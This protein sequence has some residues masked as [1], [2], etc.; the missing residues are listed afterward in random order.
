[1]NRKIFLLTLCFLIALIPMLFGADKID[2][3]EKSVVPT[4]TSPRNLLV[5]KSPAYKPIN[6][7]GK[8]G[9]LYQQIP[10]PTVAWGLACQLDTVYPMVSDIVDDIDPTGAGWVIDS[11][12]SYWSNW[13]GFYTWTLVPFID[14]LV[15][16]DDGT[17][18][19]EDSAFIKVRVPQAYYTATSIGTGEQYVVD[20]EL[21]TPVT[22]PGGAKYW[23]EVRPCT[24]FSQNGQ[25]GWMSEPGI[26][27]GQDLYIRFPLLGI[28]PWSD[29]TT[30][31]GYPFEA[32]FELYGDTIVPVAGFWDFEDGWQGWTHTNGLAFPGGWEPY[33]ATYR[34]GLGYQCP[35][36][37]DSSMCIDSDL[38]FGA[39]M[40]T[41]F[42]PFLAPL[43]TMDWL[44]YGFFY[45][46]IGIHVDYFEVGIKY[47]DGST[48][49]VD[50]LKT[51]DVSNYYGDPDSVNVSAYNTY[52]VL[53]VYF[54]YH[55]PTWDF[56]AAFDNV[57]I[58][59]ELAEH[60]VG[61]DQIASPPAGSVVF[62]GDYDVI[63]NIKNF[64]NFTETFGVK[65]DV[66]DTLDNWN[67]VF[68]ST[69]VLTNFSPGAESL[70][71]F[72]VVFFGHSD[73]YTE[74]Y[75]GLLGDQ[76]PENDTCSIYS[77][78][79]PF[80]LIWDF[81]TGWQGWTHTNGLAFPEG[82]DVL[83]SGYKPSW[84]P[85]DAGDS[86]M[87]INSDSA[88]MG[89]WVQDT[90][91]SPVIIPDATT[92]WLRWG[93]G[94]YHY[95]GQFMDV[96]IKYFDGASWT[97]VPLRT[98]NAIFWPGWDSVDVSAY[99]TSDSMQVY[100]YF[101]DINI[102]GFLASFDNVMIND[103]TG[104]AEKPGETMPLAFMLSQNAPN[105][106][107]YGQT[108]ISY[109]TT[110]KGPVNLKVYDCAGRLVRTLI[111]RNESAGHK[112]VYWDGKDAN[113][114]SVAAGVYFYRL[115]AE[116][117]TATKKMVVVR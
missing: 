15:Y 32:G 29:A 117:K 43:P 10:D 109:T 54:Y 34:S 28:D 91:L 60:D 52:D 63:G 20:M 83:A 97:V 40:D 74:I 2:T 107:R 90:A 64:G 5:E 24:D 12:T 53:Q 88:G 66:Y 67:L 77:H 89:V 92:E 98:Y 115:V 11:V 49:I 46:D 7:S 38:Y 31:W 104:V 75:T 100:F 57:S 58:D 85:P 79:P 84:T 35:N 105:P 108:T 72:G 62:V 71:N 73:Y 96:G 94:Y 47:F 45:K 8:R 22:L 116:E 78:V 106:V 13:N 33:D 48:W 16:N 114:R 18:R 56:Y 110:R 14:F 87:W 65:A 41:A 36:S 4:I 69:L 68:S 82:W 42:S 95:T 50:P 1:M 76:H 70:L 27:N 99:N 37:D 25:T 103:Y 19:P 55:A 17:I 102:W 51:Y 3:V 86:T 23:I 111:D 21:P 6:I 59:A 112:T 101:D 30:Q 81:E 93:V 113:H 44:R 80:D 61:C 39:T 26:G 9:L